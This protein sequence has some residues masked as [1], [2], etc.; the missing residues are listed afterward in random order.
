MFSKP[1]ICLC[2]RETVVLDPSLVWTNDEAKTS[3]TQLNSELQTAKGRSRE[4]VLLRF[5]AHTAKVKTP[6]VW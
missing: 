2:H 4:E 6:A 3:L 1:L 5:Y